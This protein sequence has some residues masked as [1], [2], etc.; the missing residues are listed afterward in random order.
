MTNAPANVIVSH[1]HRFIFIKNGKTASTSIEVFLSRICAASDIVTPIHP[2]VEPHCARNYEGFYNRMSGA[3]V[4]E[5]LGD[6]IWNRYYKFCVERNPWD[7]AVSYYYMARRR[8]GG[9]LSLDEYLAGD[10]FP[11]NYP[12]YTEPNDKYRIIVDRIIDF[13][14]LNEGL[15]EVFE[16]VGVPFHGA[17]GVFAKSEYRM[18]RRPYQQILKPAQAQRIREIFAVEIDLHGYRFDRS[19]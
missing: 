8:A 19:V 16:R 15:A 6:E 2:A 12:R 1:K 14:R 9:E 10:T 3:E 11:I 5:R 4:R 17:L 7:K 18:D 13:E